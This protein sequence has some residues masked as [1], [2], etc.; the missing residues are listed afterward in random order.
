MSV[1]FMNAMVGGVILLLIEGVSTVVTSISMRRQYQMME[2]MQKQELE[3]MRKAMAQGKPAN[4]WEVDYDADKAA[5]STKESETLM[6]KAKSFS[7]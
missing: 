3:R 2:E 7:F 4:P 6:D 5:K 1:A